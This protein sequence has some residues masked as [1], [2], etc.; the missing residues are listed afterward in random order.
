MDENWRREQK[1]RD[2]V[3]T[4]IIIGGILLGLFIK[5]VSIGLMIGLVLGLL[6]VGLGR[7]R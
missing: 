7:K 5:R 2:I 1:R 3:W 6:A 4:G